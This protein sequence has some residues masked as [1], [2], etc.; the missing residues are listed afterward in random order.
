MP[1][2]PVGPVTSTTVPLVYDSDT[3]G[4]GGP[5]DMTGPVIG[6]LS[7]RQSNT[8][9]LELA[10]TLDFAQANITYEIVLTC[11]PSHA[12]SCGFVSVGQLTTNAAGSGAVTI[13][14]PTAVLLSGPFGPGY[15]TDHLDMINPATGL[16]T[17]GLTAGAVNY[18]VCRRAIA[19][20]EDEAQ[21]QTPQAFTGE[22][23]PLD[24]LATTTGQDPL[25]GR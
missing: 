8:G 14:V 3:R 4:V 1:P 15:R 19:A 2:S 6:S 5:V 11:G 18:L 24:T 25:L 12:L 17:G 7:Y 21:A 13:T 22:G 9:D 10:I 23:D 20:A 16:V